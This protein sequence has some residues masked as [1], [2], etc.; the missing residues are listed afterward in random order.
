MERNCDFKCPLSLFKGL[1]LI[2][3]LLHLLTSLK[4]KSDYEVQSQ[5][6]WNLKIDGF[7]TIPAVE[8][9]YRYIDIYLFTFY[10]L[11]PNLKHHN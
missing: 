9:S 4:N 10:I 2:M 1:I 8:H 6:L 3:Y 11:L 7:N 5:C